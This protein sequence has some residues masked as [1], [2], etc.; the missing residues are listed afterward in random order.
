M[1]WEPLPHE[2]ELFS[3]IYID[4][5]SQNN[6]HYLVVGGIIVSMRRAA[7]LEREI[8]SARGK[9]LPVIDDSGK[10]HIIKWEKVKN[11]NY[12]AY[13]A[14]VDHFTTL[15]GKLGGRVLRRNR[16]SPKRSRRGAG[17]Q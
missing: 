14:V 1:P 9:A 8:K 10:P 3:E 5:S 2:A 4:E 15:G 13:M 17:G 11:H 6:H 16:V 7:W 12:R